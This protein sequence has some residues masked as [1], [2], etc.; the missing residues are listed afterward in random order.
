MSNSYQEQWPEAGRFWIR[1][2]PR[3]WPNVPTPWVHLGRSALGR[4]KASRG[5][6]PFP[7]EEK[8]LRDLVYL[9][10]V[11]AET[12][13]E[14]QSCA[15]EH[16]NRGTPVL[17]QVLSGGEKGPDG[18][19][20][21]LD[22]LP[23]LLA[24][25][26]PADLVPPGV[27]TAVWPLIP[28]ISDADEMWGAWLPELREAGV[29]VVLPQ[30]LELTPGDRRW[31]ADQVSEDAY[32]SLFHGSTPSERRFCREVH[33]AGIQ[34]F[35]PRPHLPASTPTLGETRKTGRLLAEK[36]LLAGELWD[37]LGKPPGVAHGLLSAGRW[38]DGTSYDLL[39]LAREGNLRH[40][41]ALSG[42]SLDL[43]G[44]EL[45]GES[46]GLVNELLAEYLEGDE[47]C[48]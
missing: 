32:S 33:R 2:E 13:S 17:M 16:L 10:P 11:A 36:L 47:R 15:R 28:G 23:S 26:R 29:E 24:E 44:E 4:E 12:E 45:T 39:G 38:V 21:V 35:P 40:L 48:E 14:R 1:Y 5:D 3:S 27:T 34:V 41:P 46:S 43:A 30:L 42:L 8:P 37:R 19:L 20:S 7:G 6:I 22:L 25:K 18:S 31:L 9:P